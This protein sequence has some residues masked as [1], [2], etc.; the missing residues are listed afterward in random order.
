MAMILATNV[1]ED[2]AGSMKLFYNASLLIMLAMCFDTIDGRVARLTKTQS[3]FG[4]QIDSLADV[5]SFGAAPS[6]LLY[7]WSLSEMGLTG[8]VVAFVFTAAGAIRLAR[9]NVLSSHSTGEPKAPGKYILG[10]PIPAG[11][12]MIVS[13]VVI[14][15]VITGNLYSF[16]YAVAL[17]VILVAL[18]M[19]STIRFRSFKE[20]KWN[21][22]SIALL[23]FVVGV[24]V[25][26]SWKWHKVFALAWLMG[27][28]I[29][30]GLFET[31]VS[32]FSA[33]QHSKETHVAEGKDGVK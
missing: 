15:H 5:L 23:L 21:P 33:S 6:M 3:A 24:S 7:R 29:V 31:V 13:L 8:I 14:N 4:V 25:F 20:L 32:F 2:H 30:L 27:F 19:V 9:F 12:G 28:Y 10:L 26:I 16:P 17:V 1:A 11:A 18:L 22:Q